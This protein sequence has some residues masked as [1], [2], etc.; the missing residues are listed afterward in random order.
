MKG[1]L[2][3]FDGC[4]GAL[5]EKGL[6][7][8]DGRAILSGGGLLSHTKVTSGGTAITVEI[9]I[10]ERLEAFPSQPRTWSRACDWSEKEGSQRGALDGPRDCHQFPEHAEFVHIERGLVWLRSPSIVENMRRENPRE[11]DKDKLA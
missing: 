11:V 9:T 10:G 2:K 6:G 8:I 7:A 5:C 1:L 3:P 4:G